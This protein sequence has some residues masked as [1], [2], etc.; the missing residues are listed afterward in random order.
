M[1]RVSPAL[2]AG[3]VAEPQHASPAAT[4]TGFASIRGAGF[5][6]SPYRAARLPIRGHVC[7]GLPPSADAKEAMPWQLTTTRRVRA[8]LWGTARMAAFSDRVF[9]IAATLL[10]L[11]PA[12]HPPGTPL[13]QVLH[14]WPGYL[15]YVVSFLTIGG[16]WLAH[17][18]FDRAAHPGRSDLPAN[19][20]GPAPRR[21]VP[22]IPDPAHR[23]RPSR[24]RRRTRSRHDLRADLPKIRLL[25]SAL[26]AYARREHRFSQQGDGEGFYVRRRLL[27]VVIGYVMVSRWDTDAK[28]TSSCSQ[29]MPSLVT[30]ALSTSRTSASSAASLS[31]VARSAS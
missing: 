22:A 26:D 18:A 9:S 6:R 31:G 30:S 25:G 28:G 14:A 3:L 16:A 23:R 13:E 4:A 8:G 2:V 24:S 5:A 20:L 29:V 17:T 19:Q 1:S 11:D 27:P 10:V 21:G 12:V 7:K 15:A